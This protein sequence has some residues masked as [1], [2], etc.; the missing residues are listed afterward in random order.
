M[1]NKQL[2]SDTR[3]TS[4]ESVCVERALTCGR[5]AKVRSEFVGERS[6]AAGCGKIQLRRVG[7]KKT[8]ERVLGEV[9]GTRCLLDT[10]MKRTIESIGCATRRNIFTTNTVTDQLS[11]NGVQSRSKQCYSQTSVEK[12]TPTLMNKSNEWRLMG[13]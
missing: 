1:T 11:E 5:E 7:W 12:L 4:V 2:D 6:K 9:D 13:G 10:V 3:R 8:K